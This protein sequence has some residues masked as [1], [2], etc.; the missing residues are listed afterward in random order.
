MFQKNQIFLDYFIWFLFY[1]YCK[2]RAKIKIRQ[3][4]LDITLSNKHTL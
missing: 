3:Y 1:V 2:D 4:R